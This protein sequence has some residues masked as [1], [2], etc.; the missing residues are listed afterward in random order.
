[1]G[2]DVDVP[3][4]VLFE[5]GEKNTLNWASEEKLEGCMLDNMSV[6]FEGDVA[7]L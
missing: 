7:Y 5:A 4:G 3:I 2:N 1:V 6:D